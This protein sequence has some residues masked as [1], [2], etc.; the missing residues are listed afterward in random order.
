MNRLYWLIGAGAAI[1]LLNGCSSSQPKTQTSAQLPS[2][3]A[4]S[5]AQPTVAAQPVTKTVTLL[6]P[7]SP[8]VRLS[9]MPP[10]GRP[11]PFAAL[12]PTQLKIP[13]QPQTAQVPAPKPAQA[14]GSPTTAP[15]PATLPP[16]STLPTT[17]IAT[18]PLTSIPL[19]PVA[20][21]PSPT[22]LAEGV[23][24]RGVMQ[25]GNK[26]VAIVKAPEEGTFRYVSAGESLANGKILVKRI[27]LGQAGEPRVILQQ[28]GVEVE[29]RVGSSGPIASAR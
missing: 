25:V 1:A 21:A 23:E 22:Q 18:K 4:Q 24:V 12:L 27:L 14:S 9:Q 7:T 3:P 2:P 13:L 29:R 6:P 11:D 26:L 16:P 17:P 5:F 15:A 8:T 20:P 28:N 10:S 19:P